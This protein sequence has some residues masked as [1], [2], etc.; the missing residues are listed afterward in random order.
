MALHT[1]HDAYCKVFFG[2]ETRG[3]DSN[4]KSRAMFL[5]NHESRTHFHKLLILIQLSKGKLNK[6]AFRLY[7]LQSEKGP[8]NP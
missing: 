5:S 8:G 1:L 7:W 4:F 2:N 6:M 3:R